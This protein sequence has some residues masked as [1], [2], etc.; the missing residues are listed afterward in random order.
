[1]AKAVLVADKTIKERDR[2]IAEL[3]P[4]AEAY[5]Q[6]L[7]TRGY[8]SLNKA[9]KSLNIGRNKLMKRLRTKKIL[10]KDGNES[11]PY[12]RFVNAGHFVVNHAVGRD[13]KFH[14]STRVSAKGLDYIRKV[15]L[16]SKEVG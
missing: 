4:K 3:Q 16:S 13:G 7:G 10:F 9:A 5:D 12:Q 1:M 15:L 11:I 8:M 2:L 6:F 14:S